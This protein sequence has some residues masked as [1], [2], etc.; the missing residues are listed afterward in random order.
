MEFSI[1]W[2][3]VNSLKDRNR[4]TTIRSYG[5]SQQSDLSKVIPRRFEPQTLAEQANLLTT[6]QERYR[7]SYDTGSTQPAK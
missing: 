1:S 4:K 6:V 5:T 3:S 7:V 2:N